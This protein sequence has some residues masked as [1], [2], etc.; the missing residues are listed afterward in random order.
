MT[1]ISYSKIVNNK[2][3]KYE[4]FDIFIFEFIFLLFFFSYLNTQNIW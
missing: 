4:L 2:I 3:M 1:D